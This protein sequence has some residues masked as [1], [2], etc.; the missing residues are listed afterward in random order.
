MNSSLSTPTTNLFMIGSTYAKRLEKLD[1]QTAED[2]L[3]HY[4]SRYNDF[5]LHSKI[6]RLQIGETATIKGQIISFDN[7]FSKYG[8]KFKKY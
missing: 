5:R 3:H 4:P 7:I 6:N 8:K 1:I 2:L